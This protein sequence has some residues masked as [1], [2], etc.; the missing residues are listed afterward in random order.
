METKIAG[1][2]TVLWKPNAFCPGSSSCTVL[3]VDCSLQQ[4]QEEGF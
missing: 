4:A 2:P 1:L 3:G